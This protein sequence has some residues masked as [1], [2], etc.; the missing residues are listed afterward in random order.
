MKIDRKDKSGYNGSMNK[1]VLPLLVLFA[2]LGFLIYSYIKIQKNNAITS[3]EECVAAGYPIMES[4]PEKC[5]V[6]NGPTFTHQIDETTTWI[7]QSVEAM[8]VSFKHPGN[9]EF[10]EELAE[11]GTSM[12]TVGFYLTEGDF[13]S[14]D[15]QLYALLS[16]YRDA[17]LDDIEKAKTEMDPETIKEVSIG[18]YQ[19]IEGKVTGPKERWL[20]VILKD[21][22]LFTISTFPAN[23]ENKDLTDQI[24]Q[25]ISFE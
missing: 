21:N 1:K 9:L 8:K 22:K 4:Y 16:L 10:K 23:E 14:P 25:T 19:G 2:F 13:Q 18:S 7:P 11:D 17:S 20:A 3:F 24:I 5:S 12:R 6:P 15:Y